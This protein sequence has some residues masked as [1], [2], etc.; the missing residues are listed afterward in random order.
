MKVEQAFHTLLLQR[1][2]NF[3]V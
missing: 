3:P 2:K 1:N